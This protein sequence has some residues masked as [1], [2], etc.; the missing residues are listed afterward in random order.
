MD[1][2]TSLCAAFSCTFFIGVLLHMA[3]NES[4]KRDD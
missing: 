2:F 3:I 1:T 4:S